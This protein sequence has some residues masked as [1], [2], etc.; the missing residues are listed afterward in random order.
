M[1]RTGGELMTIA[2]PHPAGT[3]LNRRVLSIMV[4]LASAMVIAQEE[5]RLQIGTSDGLLLSDEMYEQAEGWRAPPMIE[6][7]WRAPEREPRARIN[8]GYDSAYEDARLRDY[9]L[10]KTRRSNLREPEPNTLFRLEFHPR[11]RTQ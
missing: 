10:N 6:E 5:P 11:K 9:G 7:P 2:Q 4:L 8:F 1:A 3:M